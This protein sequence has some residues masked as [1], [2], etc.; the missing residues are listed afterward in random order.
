M[1]DTKI[2]FA[3]VSPL[4]RDA[5]FSEY[6]AAMPQYRR[7]K[8][9][10]L[11]RRGDK[12]R[13]LGAGVLLAR[14]LKSV[15]VNEN[16]EILLGKNSKPFLKDAQ[17][18]HFN[19]SHSGDLVMCVVSAREVGCDMELVRD[20]RLGVAERFF[21]PEEREFVGFGASEKEKNERFFRL[22]TL[23][24]SL[25]KANGA[26]LSLPLNTF[27]L[28]RDGQIKHSVDFDGQEYVFREID[29][30]REGYKAAICVLG[31]DVKDEPKIVVENF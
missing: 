1:V 7:E 19:L 11:K 16:A 29:T 5:L 23:K 28:L 2:Y 3:D 14:A 18:V 10:L 20:G 12:L 4:E 31:G 26:G 9:D 22:W 27:S 6:Y 21:T 24:E 13:S 15:G 8:I 17:Y 30:G 25:I